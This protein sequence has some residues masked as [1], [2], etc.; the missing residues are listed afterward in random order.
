MPGRAYGLATAVIACVAAWVA[1]IWLAISFGSSARS[2]Q[3]DAW[4]FL[5]LAAVGAVACL[6]LG[7]M[8]GARLLQ[9]VGLVEPQRP[10]RH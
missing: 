10:H 2:G 6:F 5:A 9:S 7:L 1:L 3:T 8:L 4:A